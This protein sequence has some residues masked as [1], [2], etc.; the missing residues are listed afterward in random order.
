MNAKAQKFMVFDLRAE[1]ESH[2]VPIDGAA[3][4]EWHRIGIAVD[5]LDISLEQPILI[6][7]HTGKQSERARN[8]LVYMGYTHV[9]NGGSWENA[10]DSATEEV[11]KLPM[12]AVHNG[13]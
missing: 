5:E 2:Q 13:A 3:R 10:R 12:P 8:I 6:Y 11:F 4:V 9:V 1:P 7:C